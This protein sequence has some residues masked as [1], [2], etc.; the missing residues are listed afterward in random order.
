MNTSLVELNQDPQNYLHVVRVNL[1][2]KMCIQ[3]TGVISHLLLL[4]LTKITYLIDSFENFCTC[5]SPEFCLH[6]LQ[7]T[8]VIIIIIMGKYKTMKKIYIN[9]NLVTL[10]GTVNINHDNAGRVNSKIS[11]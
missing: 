11:E 3:Q 6:Y 5:F 10:T 7:E 8:A 1:T 4:Q 9:G 2:R